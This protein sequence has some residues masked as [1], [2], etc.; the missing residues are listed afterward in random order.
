MNSYPIIVKM[1]SEYFNQN[2][3]L[4]INNKTVTE[5]LKKETRPYIEGTLIA[6]KDNTYFIPF[7]T[8]INQRF[9]ELYENA[10]LSLA[11]PKNPNAGLDFTKMIIVDNKV[12][13]RVEKTGVDTEQFK[14]LVSK[15]PELWN[16]AEN[17]VEGYKREIMNGESLSPQY[18]Y[19]TLQNFHHELGLDP[20]KQLK[21]AIKIIKTAYAHD[22][23]SG[24]AIK[25]LSDSKVP[26]CQRLKVA[27]KIIAAK[28][29]KTKLIPK[30]REQWR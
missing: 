20:S 17:Y 25:Y 9:A 29:P 30:N 22:K 18:R 12:D 27:N 19:T 21:K 26:M 5:G 24:D 15:Q 28:R 11:T 1:S 13:L 3:N 8:H 4:K 10:I 7:R 23:T 6:D 14:L 2:G 16:K